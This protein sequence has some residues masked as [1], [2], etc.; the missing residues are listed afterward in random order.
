MNVITGLYEEKGFSA[1][2]YYIDFGP[3]AR[4]AGYFMGRDPVELAKRAKY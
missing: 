3:V 4:A 2:W 1:D